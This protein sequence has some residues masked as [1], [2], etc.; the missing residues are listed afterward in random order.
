MARPLSILHPLPSTLYPLSSTLY[1][2]PSTLY[3]GKKKIWLAA[4]AYRHR[5]HLPTEEPR[6]HRPQLL[7]TALLLAHDPCGHWCSAAGRPLLCQWF[8]PALPG[9][10][11]H[12]APPRHHPIRRHACLLAR[13]PYCHRHR[14]TLSSPRHLLR[15]LRRALPCICRQ[16]LA[17]RRRLCPHRHL[18]QRL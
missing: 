14:P 7:R 4:A 6:F 18:F 16:H 9:H 12:V 5:H 15:R 17:R 11:V 3:Y 2:L 8:H 10:R 13:C 1:P